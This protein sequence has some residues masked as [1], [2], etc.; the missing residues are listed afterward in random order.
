MMQRKPL[1]LNNG[2]HDWIRTSDLFRVKA[3]TNALSTTYTWVRELPIT[4]NYVQE[5]HSQPILGLEFGS[6]SI[7]KITAIPAFRL[8]KRASGWPDLP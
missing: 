8:L 4:L 6:A 5:R 2:R 1:I 7:S 3:G